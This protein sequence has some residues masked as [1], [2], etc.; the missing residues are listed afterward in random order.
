MST[1]LKSEMTSHTATQFWGGDARGVCIQI[2]SNEEGFIQLTMEEA[3]ALCNTLGLFIVDE[4]K[5]RQD[6]LKEE[7]VQLKLDERTVFHEVIELDSGLMVGPALAV[8]MV[9]KLCPKV[10]KEK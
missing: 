9:S 1:E 6:L 7:L 5:R 4:A 2:T 8:T 3:A 10:R